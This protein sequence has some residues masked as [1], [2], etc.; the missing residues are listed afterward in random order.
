MTRNKCK[1][2]YTGQATDHVC[3][4]W[5]NYHIF[6]DRGEE[7]MQEHLHRHLESE[8]HSDFRDHV[9]VILTDKT[10]GSNPTKRE[11]YWMRTLKTIALHGPNVENDL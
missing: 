10:D 1:N 5:N 4:R 11:T 2:Q 8:L 9:S 3:S 7:C 6:F